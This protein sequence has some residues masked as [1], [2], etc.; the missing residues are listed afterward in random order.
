MLYHYVEWAFGTQPSETILGRIGVYGVGIFYV[1]SGLTLRHVYASQMAARKHDVCAFFIRRAFRIFPMLWLVTLLMILLQQQMV[2]PTDLWLNFTGLFAL[3]KWEDHHAPVAWSIGNELVFY[4]VF[5]ALMLLSSRWRSG[6]L[7]AAVLTFCLYIYFA[8][9]VLTIDHTLQ[10]Q[11]R[12]YSNPLNQVFLFLG[13]FLIGEWGNKITLTP[14][15]RWSL[16]LTGLAM[17]VFYPASGDLITLV[18][19]L[20]RILFT[21][22]CFMICLALYRIEIQIPY[23]IEWPLHQLGLASYAVYLFHPIVFLALSMLMQEQ[24][25]GEMLLPVRVW[26]PAAA[27]LT[28]LAS[29]LSYRY[30][31]QTFIRI[32]RLWANQLRERR[33][34]T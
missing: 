26:L 21:L 34:L 17:L 32:G 7:L 30:F 24:P 22:A 6:L 16:L 9:S 23:W 14:L 27:A 25:G 18:V 8:F 28:L 13:G 20:N 2:N 15:L 10:T 4:L 5:P 3:F 31:E 12:T 33:R 1:L 11:W 29:L 19:G